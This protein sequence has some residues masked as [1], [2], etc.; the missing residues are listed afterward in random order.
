MVIR[1]KSRGIH[2]TRLSVCTCERKP[3]EHQE[4]YC[5]LKWEGGH[6]DPSMVARL[7]EFRAGMRV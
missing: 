7:P 6:T 1:R 2:S 5:V 4:I 3:R